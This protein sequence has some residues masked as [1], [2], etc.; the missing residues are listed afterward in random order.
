MR[1]LRSFISVTVL[2]GMAFAGRDG[3]ARPS[4]FSQTEKA[5]CRARNGKAEHIGFGEKACVIPY[6]DGGR[7]CRGKSD[8][9]GQCV[10]RLGLDPQPKF[11]GY[12]AC[13]RDNATL[14]C[15]SVVEHGELRPEACTD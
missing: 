5:A 6:A 9:Q 2:V 12:G 14:G 4:H 10:F 11:K 7:A 15:F 1:A 3:F 13:E 8:C